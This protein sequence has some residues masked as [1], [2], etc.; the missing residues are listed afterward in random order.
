V[1]RFNGGKAA[2]LSG[3]DSGHWAMGIAICAVARRVDDYAIPRTNEMSN[4]ILSDLAL[5]V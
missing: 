3:T 5:V 4:V 2:L 1:Q